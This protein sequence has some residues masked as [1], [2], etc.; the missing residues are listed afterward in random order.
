MRIQLAAIALAATLPAV[1]WLAAPSAARADEAACRVLETPGLFKDTKVDQARMVAAD[2]AQGLPAYCELKAVI[3]PVPQSKIAIV[4][5][6][7]EAWNGKM[8]GLGGGGWSGNVTLASASQGLKKGYATAQTNG[9][10]DTKATFETGWA[11]DNPVAVTDFSY[12]AIHLT[13]VI[14]KAVV[15]S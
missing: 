13:A 9:G 15:K 11:K 2:A 7:P 8:L 4:V 5:R 6:L 14:G 10:H 3:S 12:R 1:A